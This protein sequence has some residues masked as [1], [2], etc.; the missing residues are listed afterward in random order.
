MRY[1]A[2]A[3]M[4]AMFVT[5]Q[6]WAAEAPQAGK[7]GWIALFDGK[8]LTGW[9]VRHENQKNLWVVEG[10]VLR[11]TGTGTDLISDVPLVDHEL[12]VEYRTPPGGNS[13]VYLQGRYE[14][15]VGD[16]T[17]LKKLGP[18][19]PGAIYGKIVPSKNVS[20]PAGEWQ[21][22]DITFRSARLNAEGKIAQKARITVIHNGEKII[23][24]AEIDGVTG[25]AVDNKEGT[26]A[27]LMLQGDHSAMDYRN[28][29]HRPILAEK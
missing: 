11:N 7:E 13:G 18:G 26:P 23:D 3:V 28:I 5:V 12:H 19:M 6:A 8:D 15:Q 10:G 25:S 21:S 16:G 2:T 22:F 4:A 17:N 24:N 1:W 20:K 14:V 9:H 29:V 27:G